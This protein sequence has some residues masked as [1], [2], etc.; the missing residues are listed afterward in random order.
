[1]SSSPLQFTNFTYS[2][3]TDFVAVQAGGELQFSEFTN[4][5][6][7]QVE[8]RKNLSLTGSSASLTT[9]ADVWTPQEAYFYTDVTDQYGRS[10][11]TYWG[12]Q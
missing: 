4:Q 9:V 6:G 11:H 3:P 12:F 8:V 2:L 10:F 1:L 7:G 5:S